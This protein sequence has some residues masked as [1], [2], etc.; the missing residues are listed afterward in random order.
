MTISHIAIG[1]EA[2]EFGSWDWIGST[3]REACADVGMQVETFADP[4][5]PPPAEIVIYVKFLPTAERLAELSRHSNIVFMPVDIYGSVAEIVAYADRLRTLSLV[6]VHSR[7]LVRYF[8]NVCPTEF[9]DHPLRYITSSRI[10]LADR[11]PLIWLGRRCNLMPSL[12]WWQRAAAD[13]PLTV[14]TNGVEHLQPTISRLRPTAHINLLE[15][16]PETHLQ[17]LTMGGTA[18]DIK[19]TDF[20]ERH[21]PPAKTFDYLASG[22]PVI[23]NVGS[24]PHIHICSLPEQPPVKFVDADHVLVESTP[25]FSAFLR[26]QLTKSRVRDRVLEMI[27]SSRTP[28]QQS[29]IISSS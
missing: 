22:I 8:S 11:R 1:P 27:D 17:V 29:T 4:A 5:A 21:K 13:R 26:D 7:R 19:G 12:T 20:R 16:T 10:S 14:V 23:T 3:L 18:I 6:L 15:W 24:S 28:P 2:P 9:I 25:H